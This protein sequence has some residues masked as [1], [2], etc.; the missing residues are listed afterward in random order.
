MFVYVNSISKL[1][2]GFPNTSGFNTDAQILQWIDDQINNGGMGPNQEL[3]ASHEPFARPNVEEKYI[4]VTPVEAYFNEAHPVYTMLKQWRKIYDQSDIPVENKL[5]AV[6]D[7]ES[8]ANE[9]VVPVQKRTKT[10]ALA[11]YALM[12]L[13]NM[14]TNAKIDASAI[15]N[16]SKKYLRNF[17]KPAKK[18]KT[19]D[20]V[21]LAKKALLTANPLSNPD[22]N[23]DWDLNDFTEE[24]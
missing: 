15:S 12:E 20:D 7:K 4:L 24:A 2:E 19:N 10:T 8:E 9:T 21:K 22:L 6:D 18:L 5:V 16:K 14:D 23:T 11:V 3:V 17:L 1:P 13:L